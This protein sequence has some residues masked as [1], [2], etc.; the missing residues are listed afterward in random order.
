MSNQ[1]LD[2]ISL[3]KTVTISKLNCNKLIQRRLLDLGIIGSTKITPVLK[4]SIGNLVAYEIRNN[5]IA[6]RSEDACLIEVIA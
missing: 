1:T 4:S 6:L 3:G 5:I 2:R